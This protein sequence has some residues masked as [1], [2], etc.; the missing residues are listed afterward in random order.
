[1]RSTDSGLRTATPQRS[2]VGT[3]QRSRVT[4]A[5]S[6]RWSRSGSPG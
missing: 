5:G 2:D 3:L 1:M 6:S 4:A